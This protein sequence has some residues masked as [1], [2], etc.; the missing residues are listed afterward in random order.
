VKFK[1]KTQA[2]FEYPGNL[3]T[4]DLATMVQ[5]YRMRGEPYETKSG[6]IIAC[7]LTKKLLK[8]S[9]NWFGLHYSQKAWDTL[10]TTNSGG[11]PLTKVELNI[12][13]L[14]HSPPVEPMGRSFVENNCDVLPQL[15]FL[16][17]N[18]LKQFGFLQEDDN[19]LIITPSGTKAL[20]GIA[21]RVFE[22]KFLPEM[23]SYYK[24]QPGGHSEPSDK[25]I[26]LF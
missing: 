3:K 25:Q 10:L 14:V 20:D 4:L 7:A 12:L 9:K 19:E 22:R 26:R 18:D 6:E 2:F 15:A 1:A 16:I 23:L 24:E 21:R 13:G 5:L 17:I 8:S 11:F